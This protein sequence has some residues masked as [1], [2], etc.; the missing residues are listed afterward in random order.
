MVPEPQSI[1]RVPTQGALARPGHGPPGER[2]DQAA[3]CAL[4]STVC[5]TPLQYGYDPGLYPCVR[6]EMR[7]MVCGSPLSAASVS[8]DVVASAIL[9]V[10]PVGRNDN[11]LVRARVCEYLR[12]CACKYDDLTSLMGGLSSGISVGSRL[13]CLKSPKHPLTLHCTLLVEV[14]HRTAGAGDGQQRAP[15]RA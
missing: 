2:S 7:A 15:G 3:N 1:A 4:R 10:A 12:L 8:R 11:A 9:C 6:Y 14:G 13:R 5:A